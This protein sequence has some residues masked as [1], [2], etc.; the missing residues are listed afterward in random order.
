MPAP[1]LI[2][3]LGPVGA[4]LALLLA[5]QGVPVLAIE[6]DTEPYPL[7][8]AVALDDEALRVLQAAGVSAANGLDLLAGVTVRLRGRS[9][10]TLLSLPPLP[11]S[12]GHPGLTFFHQPQLER[13]LHARLAAEPLIDT[14]LGWEVTALSEAGGV[15][16]VD[17]REAG[18]DGQLRQRCASY[19]VACDGA[20]STLRRLLGV[21]LVGRTAGADWL[22]VDTEASSLP[23]P[24]DGKAA[25]FD[26][27]AFEFACN[28]R[29]PWVH[30]PL[31]GNAH[32][33]EF[34]LGPED[35][36]R[37]AVPLD[38]VTAL[39]EARLSAPAPA[40]LRAAVYTFHT[41]IAARWRVGHTLLA[42][43]AAHLAP[44][45]AGQGLGTGLRD[46]HNLAWKLAA[47]VKSRASAE[48]LDTYSRERMPHVIRMTALAA[49][50]GAIVQTRRPRLAAARDST[51]HGLMQSARV[52][53]WVAAG[54]WKPPSRVAGGRLILRH[55]DHLHRAGEPL[56]QPRLLVDDRPGTLLDD[57][58]GP[59][60][61]LLGIGV[62]P[63]ESL[64]AE[65]R[66]HSLAVAL[67]VRMVRIGPGGIPEESDTLAS[68]LY[69]A[70]IALVRPDRVVVGTARDASGTH[71]LLDVLTRLSSDTAV[72]K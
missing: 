67:G 46:V 15:V 68:W 59:G 70:R 39:L 40:I 23:D 65:A 61:V 54:G 51:M 44:P 26:P 41:R 20:R 43:D 52:R 71:A 50:I 2:V 9:G 66:T 35:R 36:M 63:M 56:P 30:G 69:P 34:M 3:G 47:V 17:T 37:D 31:P 45:F 32:R 10:D 55:P 21:Q 27:F 38:A 42:G 62:D 72:S 60:F 58:L 22:V 4:T 12:V 5:G 24:G 57:L 8:R 19:V 6:R 13:L 28:P 16:R 7:A 11:G 29:R 49:G 25:S 18:G 64:P 33:W 1:V 53:S 48:L 14:C